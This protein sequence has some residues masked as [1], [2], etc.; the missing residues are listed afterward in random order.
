MTLHQRKAANKKKLY[1]S[2]ESFKEN[3]REKKNVKANEQ[4]ENCQDKSFKMPWKKVIS[5]FMISMLLLFVVYWTSNKENF[6]VLASQKDKLQLITAEVPCSQMYKKEI[7]RFKECIPKQ[8]GRLVTDIVI[9]PEEAANLLQIAK[10][11]FAL[12]GSL[13]GASI[14][15]LHS[16]ALSYANSFINIYEKISTQNKNVFT[17]EDFKVYSNVRNKIQQIVA[18]NFGIPVTKLYLTHPT[19]FSEMTTRVAK[20]KH[21]E[22]WH[23][24]V[25]KE[26]YPS[27]YY[28][29]LLYLSDYGI[30]FS[31]GRFV[32]VSNS[33][34]MTVEPRLGRVSAFTSG[35]EN[36]HYVE[37]VNS[38][39]RYALTVSFTCD[40]KFAISDPT[41]SKFQ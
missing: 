14:L 1:D 38:G 17:T 3:N 20:T 7:S 15:D 12:G 31:G 27:F 18:Y 13:G 16:G 21:D 36:P 9:T 29:S 19:F 33:K 35:S 34:N 32:F 37:R 4:N 41:T 10:K 8:C 23:I 26:T 30:D 39:T 28:T 22:Y 25:D 24:H 40:P 5:R 2:K 6:H 11:G